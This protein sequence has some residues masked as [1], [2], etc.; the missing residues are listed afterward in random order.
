MVEWRQGLGNS[1]LLLF[2]SRCTILIETAG[3]AT[4][5][6]YSFERDSFIGQDKYFSY[7]WQSYGPSSPHKPRKH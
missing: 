2:L 5:W 7:D 4:Y 6:R 3:C 1:G